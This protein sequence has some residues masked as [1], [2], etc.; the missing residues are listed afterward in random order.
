M[1]SAMRVKDQLDKLEQSQEI[2]HWKVH[3]H[4][5]DHLL[6]IVTDKMSPEQVKHYIRETGFDAD[7]VKAPQ[8][9]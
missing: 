8:A 5:P 4:S 9:D 7:F 1:T 3:V 6:E 2:D